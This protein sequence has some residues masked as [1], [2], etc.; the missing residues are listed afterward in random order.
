VDDFSKKTGENA[1]YQEMLQESRNDKQNG[2]HKAMPVKRNAAP[3]FGASG[4]QYEKP[5]RCKHSVFAQK[6]K[7]G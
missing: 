6:E 2:G 7:T 3:R 5:P 4:A 1:G